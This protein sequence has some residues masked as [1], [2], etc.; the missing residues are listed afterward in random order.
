MIKERINQLRELN[1]SNDKHFNQEVRS[2][3]QH[4]VSQ[5]VVTSQN[6]NKQRTQKTPSVVLAFTYGWDVRVGLFL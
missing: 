5:R 1:K 6:T 4:G 3:F 2:T